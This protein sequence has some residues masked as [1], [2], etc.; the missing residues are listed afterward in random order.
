MNPFDVP[1]M[2]G[3]PVA[4]VGDVMLDRY[5]QGP[6]ARISPEAPVPIVRIDDVSER[7]GGAAN[8]ALNL[9]TLGA[10]PIL[11]GV[12]GDDGAADTL[13]RLLEDA[14]V[15]CRLLRLPEAAT[16]TKLRVMSHGQQLIRLDAERP[17]TE[18]AAATLHQQ[19]AD[20]L[21]GARVL[22]CSDYGKGVLAE[23][24]DL[25]ARA[26]QLGVPALVDPKD[27]DFGRYAGAS[28]VKP[29][30]SE[31][32]TVVGRCASNDETLAGRAEALARRHE[33]GAL[34]VTRGEQGMSLVRPDQAPLHLPTRAREVFDVTGA[35]DTVIATLGAALAAG[36]SL[37]Y[38]TALANAAAGV[39]V[40]KVGTATVTPHELR[41]AVAA[42]ASPSDAGE[43]TVL[44]FAA[45]DVIDAQTV[46][47]LE[48]A[49]ALGD[50]LVVAVPDGGGAAPR[51]AA[52][53]GALRCV[54]Q[55]V[56]CDRA[57][58]EALIRRLRPQYLV[59]AGV[60]HPSEVPGYG[61]MVA[62]GGEVRLVDGLTAEDRAGGCRLG[63]TG[64]AV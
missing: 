47:R 56:D 5:W 17:F 20:E 50:R 24:A 38:A 13:T 19:A 64:G 61:E 37:D 8:V 29:N 43:R 3:L 39:V 18:K 34:L 48:A 51:A 10:R 62:I 42:A 46:A 9:A 14:G 59:G 36:R 21:D 54:D 55:V 25:L 12:A 33:I 30:R 41:Q 58:D 52:L 2:T 31:F 11:Y 63:A 22:V 49:R 7:P 26:R 1:D 4:V 28:V 15:V 32:E 40:G 27:E 45:L 53:L 57:G 35:G 44:M 23:P 16:I 6:T 60:G